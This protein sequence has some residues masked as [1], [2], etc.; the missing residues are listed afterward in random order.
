MA[1]EVRDAAAAGTHRLD[2][3]GTRQGV[4]A[5]ARRRVDPA[6][7][8]PVDPDYA[9]PSASRKGRAFAMAS[10][11]SAA[12]SDSQTTA[13]PLQYHASAPVS[14]AVRISTLASSPPSGPT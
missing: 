1:V 4:Y 13:P 7:R 10:A 3:P 2:Q 6:I 8:D 11:C 5:P 9:H 14:H 12:G